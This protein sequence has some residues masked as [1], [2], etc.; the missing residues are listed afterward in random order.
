MS[1]RAEER[2]REG[3]R[4]KE[5]EGRRGREGRGEGGREKEGE[6]ERPLEHP[7]MLSS[8]GWPRWDAGAGKVKLLIASPIKTRPKLYHSPLIVSY[9]HT[10]TA[11][12]CTTVSSAL[13][14]AR[15]V[16]PKLGGCWTC[17]LRASNGLCR[18]RRAAPTEAWKPRRSC[19][20]QQQLP[21]RRARVRRPSLPRRRSSAATISSPASK[22]PSSRRRRSIHCHSRGRPLAAAAFAWADAAASCAC[23]AAAAVCAATANAG[24]TAV[25][26][27][28][29]CMDTLT[30]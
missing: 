29:G 4:K 25:S 3:G 2:E 13:R 6:G 9:R 17:W 20:Q 18:R 8:S 16:C 28:H 24:H 15:H 26:G 19:Q 11:N 5:G 23:A 1:E 10:G 21:V 22:A 27:A 30:T 12:K 14:C 7:G